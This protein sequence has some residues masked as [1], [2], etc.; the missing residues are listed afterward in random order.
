[1][2][3]KP[4]PVIPRETVVRLR[5]LDDFNIEIGVGFGPLKGRI[6]RIG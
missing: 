5:L 4:D 3:D 6:W 1:L 2:R